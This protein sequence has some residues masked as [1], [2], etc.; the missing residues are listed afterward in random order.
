M[1]FFLCI[2]FEGKWAHGFWPIPWAEQGFI[3]DMTFLEPFPLVVALILRQR[4]FANS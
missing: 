1:G 3:R 4:Q 2:Y